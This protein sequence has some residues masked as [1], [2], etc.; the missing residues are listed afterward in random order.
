MNR[1]TDAERLPDVSPDNALTGKVEIGKNH[2]MSGYLPGADYLCVERTLRTILFRKEPK[3]VAEPY[4]A[5]R[6]HRG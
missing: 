1:V 2:L 4:N 3:R 5:I 6:C